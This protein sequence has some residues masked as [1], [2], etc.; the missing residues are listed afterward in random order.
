MGENGGTEIFLELIILFFYL[1]YWK[2]ILKDWWKEWKYYKN[3]TPY[4]KEL[5]ENKFYY[6]FDINYNHHSFK[7]NYF[8]SV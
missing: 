7:V 8:F 2:N 1:N 3:I 6:I 4:H 5:K